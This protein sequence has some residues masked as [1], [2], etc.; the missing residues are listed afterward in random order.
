MPLSESSDR[1]I[2]YLYG[3]ELVAAY[4]RR[5]LSPVEVTTTLLRRLERLEPRI[6]AFVLVARE[7]ALKEGR[8][9]EA[10]WVNGGPLGLLCGAPPAIPRPLPTHRSPTPP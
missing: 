6:N 7:S 10:R 4:R 2:A 8:A 9:G 5:T 3:T 1:D